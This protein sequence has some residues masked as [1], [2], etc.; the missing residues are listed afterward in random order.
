VQNRRPQTRNR[1]SSSISPVRTHNSPI[2]YDTLDAATAAA[3]ATSRTQRTQPANHS[4][5]PS[6]NTSQ[7]TTRPPSRSESQ[8]VAETEATVQSPPRAD[9]DD[10]SSDESIV[11]GTE[12]PA[13]PPFD[14]GR[15]DSPTANNTDNERNKNDE[16]DNNDDDDEDS[17]E[18]REEDEDSTEE[19]GTGL[20]APNSGEGDYTVSDFPVQQRVMHFLGETINRSNRSNVETCLL[21]EAGTAVI[22]ERTTSAEI[23]NEMMKDKYVNLVRQFR[24]EDFDSSSIQDDM[25]VK[26]FHGKSGGF[27]GYKLWRKFE[28]S[29][30]DIRIHYIPKLP[31]DISNY[32]S[33]HSLRD[34]Y[35][36]F[37]VAA[38]K[39]EHNVS[40]KSIYFNAMTLLFTVHMFNSSC[41][42]EKLEV[43]ADEDES[44]MREMPKEY[45][46]KGAKSKHLLACMVHR[47]NKEI[48]AECARLP[49]AQTR[50]DQRRAAAARVANERAAASKV[51][52]NQNAEEKKEKRIRLMIAE[53]SLIK[54]KNDL[55]TT[56][57]EL[58]NRNKSSYVAALGQEAYDNKIISLLNELPRSSEVHNSLRDDNDEDS[59]GEE[60][61]NE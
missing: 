21:I 40:K 60:S 13:L 47:C 53:N 12:V 51:R 48:A 20:F 49:S 9:D 31:K 34:V 46:L 24:R 6:R 25:A 17:E 57:L 28:E 58:Y 2:G 32:P 55:I 56:Q 35:K 44:V 36:K 52:S 11:P 18:E 54:T 39:L 5:P 8:I 16:G 22:N 59:D 10:S 30:R 50:E 26:L 41:F 38:Y 43:A 19:S 37:A 1:G 42:N 14:F 7:N 29:R 33:G 15:D 4:R 23:R 3:A 61:N 45:W 27:T